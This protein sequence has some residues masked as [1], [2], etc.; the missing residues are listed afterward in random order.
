MDKILKEWENNFYPADGR[1]VSELW[2]FIKNEPDTFGKNLIPPF[3]KT[4]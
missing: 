3:M 4:T 1:A 2:E